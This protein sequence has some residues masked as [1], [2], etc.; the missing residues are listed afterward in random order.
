[1]RELNLKVH[2]LKLKVH[3][4]KLKVCGLIVLWRGLLLRSG[5]M[6]KGSGLAINVA[7][8]LVLFALH[9]VVFS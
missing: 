3:E 8:P 9:R 4:L 6:E 1:M 7:S 2:E 5:D